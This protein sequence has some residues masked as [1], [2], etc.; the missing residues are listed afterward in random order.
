MIS[1]MTTGLSFLAK[2]IKID[3]LLLNLLIKIIVMLVMYRMLIKAKAIVM[4]SS[5]EM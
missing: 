1:K 4:K 3:N 2:I 5:R